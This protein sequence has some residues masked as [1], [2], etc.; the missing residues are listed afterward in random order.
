M[1]TAELA[2]PSLIALTEHPQCEVI[3]VY[4]QPDRPAGRGQALQT[5]PIKRCAAELGRPI[6]QPKKLREPAAVDELATLQPELIVVVAYG[7]ILPPPVLEL[8]AHGCLN[9][10]ASILPRHR[11]AAPIQ[12][13]ILEG[14]AETG[15]TLM[16]MDEGL[17]TGGIVAT[18]TT[19]IHSEDNAKS[20]HER[21]ANIG[22]ELLSNRLSDF[23]AGKLPP[24]PQPA[25][26][27]TYAGKIDKA[28]GR[29]DWRQSAAHIHRQIRAFTPWPGAFTFL[30]VERNSR[31]KITEAKIAENSG[32]PGTVL[33]ANDSGIT[34]AC[35]NGALTVRGVQREGAKQMTAAEFLRGFELKAGTILR[36]DAGATAN[37]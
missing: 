4:T 23:L 35:G 11:G 20:L 5:S 37:D 12:S 19:P 2:L 31:L 22:A 1:G 18:Q 30:P 17:D 24:Q 26:G 34:I 9:V 32:T 28:D 10:H 25:K 7:Q 36:G 33:N 13:A 15:V 29:I 8:P 27:A 6:F 3:G 16:Q 14:D 21:L